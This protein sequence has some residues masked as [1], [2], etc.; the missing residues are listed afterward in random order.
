MNSSRNVTA[1]SEFFR[2]GSF[3]LAAKNPFFTS[4]PLIWINSFTQG[5]EGPAGLPIS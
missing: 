1:G 4:T 3:L 2:A 5:V